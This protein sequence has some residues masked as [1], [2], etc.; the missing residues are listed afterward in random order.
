MS[1][2]DPVI[3]TG[4]HA[5]L[6]KAMDKARRGE[7]IR[8]A[9]IGGSITEGY[10]S[11]SHDKCYAKRVHDWWV[12]SFP[13]SNVRYINAGIGGTNSDY[14][15]SRVEKDI[16]GYAPDVVFVD[17][18]VND[19]DTE[20]YFETYEGLLRRILKS[21]SQPAVALM[22]FVQYSCGVSA[23]EWHL[24]LGQYYGLPCI[25]CVNS[26]YE[27]LR[28]GV[29]KAEEFTQDMLHPNDYGHELI[30]GMVTDFLDKIKDETADPAAADTAIP[31]P[32]SANAWEGA[33]RLQNADT[34]AQIKGFEKDLKEAE[35][36]GDHFRGGW[37]GK[38][39]GDEIVFKLNCS[40]IS[41]QLKRTVKRPAPVALAIVDG[42]EENAVILDANFDQ[43]WGDCLSVV[44]V[45]RHG[46]VLTGQ[47][48]AGLS[49]ARYEK[50]AEVLA[51][52]KDVKPQVKEHE[53]KI[54]IIGTPEELNW[55]LGELITGGPAWHKSEGNDAP[56]A[57]ELISIFE[58]APL[59]F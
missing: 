25:S 48:D 45:M 37:I 42:D 46:C 9:F 2:Y 59:S 44:P 33:K 40:E 27:K 4:D 41:V 51:K 30:A 47:T 29:I 24:K 58:A 35:Y 10:S 28:D 3:N 13:D 54:R 14:G 15:A 52:Y 36:P 38:K 34:D 5:K 55:K 32:L 11:T 12:K 21:S 50:S 16:L 18:S 17:F 1:K 20:F 19:A 26:I 57:F 23:Q 7:D 39:A 53:L 49:P 56:A 22:F 8:I 31:A 43:D 6:I